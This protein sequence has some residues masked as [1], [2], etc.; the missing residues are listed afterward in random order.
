MHLKRDDLSAIDR[1]AEVRG[2]TYGMIITYVDFSSWNLSDPAWVDQNTKKFIIG[3]IAGTLDRLC[4]TIFSIFNQT[5]ELSI[6]INLLITPDPRLE[7]EATS[8]ASE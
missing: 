4:S 2:L 8:R 6:P 1:A 3:A 5:I 7:S